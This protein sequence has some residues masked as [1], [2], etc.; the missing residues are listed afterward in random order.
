MSSRYNRQDLRYLSGKKETNLMIHVDFTY[1]LLW[2][3]RMRR[4]LSSKNQRK[5]RLR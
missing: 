5:R 4:S 1:Q 3:G 2:S